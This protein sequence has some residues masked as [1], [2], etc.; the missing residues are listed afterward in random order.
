MDG[1]I[2]DVIV[3]FGWNAKRSEGVFSVTDN[4]ID[5]VAREN[6]LAAE[7]NNVRIVAGQSA[8]IGTLADVKEGL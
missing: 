2:M 7:Y 3:V 6:K 8:I 1:R 4:L 5:A